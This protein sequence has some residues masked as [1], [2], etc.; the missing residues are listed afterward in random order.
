M[1]Y[2]VDPVV[3]VSIE[4]NFLVCVVETIGGR[5]SIRFHAEK[6][7]T[8]H[9]G[10]RACVDCYQKLATVDFLDCASFMLLNYYFGIGMARGGAPLAQQQT[11]IVVLVV[12]ILSNA[13]RTLGLDGLL[14]KRR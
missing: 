2:R 6:G 13:G 8:S 1:H 10:A 7:I 3:G 12:L 14:F 9:G 4:I 5:R 11:F